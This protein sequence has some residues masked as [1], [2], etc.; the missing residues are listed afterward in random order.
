VQAVDLPQQVFGRMHLRRLRAAAE[1]GLE[2]IAGELGAEA[3]DIRVDFADPAG[4]GET[5]A[6]VLIAPPQT[7]PRSGRRLE[8]REWS[9]TARLT[10]LLRLG[11][12]VF[13]ALRR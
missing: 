10:E 8:R 11:A 6:P 2:L 12:A 13:A 3:V 7:T 4:R 5:R 1:D 9:A